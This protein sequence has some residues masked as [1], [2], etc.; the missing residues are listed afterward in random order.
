MIYFS[1]RSRRPVTRS[2]GNPAHRPAARHGLS[3]DYRVTIDP[4]RTTDRFSQTW[5]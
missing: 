3:S 5:R 1:P 4:W 2:A